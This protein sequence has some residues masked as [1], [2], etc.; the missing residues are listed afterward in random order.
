MKHSCYSK[1]KDSERNHASRLYTLVATYRSDGGKEKAPL[2]VSSP[3]AKEGSTGCNWSLRLPLI[4]IQRK[5]EL[6]GEG[7]PWRD[8]EIDRTNLGKDKG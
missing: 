4:S 5:K 6:K 8:E 2:A 7:S 1:L 3:V